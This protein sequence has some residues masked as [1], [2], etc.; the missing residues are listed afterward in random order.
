MNK[1]IF[2]KRNFVVILFLF[3]TISCMR[4]KYYRFSYTSSKIG[5]SGIEIDADVNHPSFEGDLTGVNLTIANR[6]NIDSVKVSIP[7]SN[8]FLDFETMLEGTYIFTYPDYDSLIMNNYIIV[9]IFF[10]STKTDFK[11]LK[12]EMEVMNEIRGH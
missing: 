1:N 6:S 5:S 3:L 7:S 9:S 4:E 2:I 11:L 10:D 12:K 8:S